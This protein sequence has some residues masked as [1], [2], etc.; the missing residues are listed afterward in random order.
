[1]DKNM[2][3]LNLLEIGIVT[4]CNLRC[5]GCNHASPLLDE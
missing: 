1:M 5:I 4:H 2:I 3:L